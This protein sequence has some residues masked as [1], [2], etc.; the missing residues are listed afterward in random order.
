MDKQ[1]STKIKISNQKF[2]SGFATEQTL[3]RTKPDLGIV[4][5]GEELEPEAESGEH[6]PA[7]QQPEHRH[8]QADGHVPSIGIY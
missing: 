2:R 5:L 4:L 1:C 3:N 6:E 8:V 7:R